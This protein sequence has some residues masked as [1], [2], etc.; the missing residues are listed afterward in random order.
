VVTALT[1]LLIGERAWTAIAAS[2]LATV[3]GYFIGEL[4]LAALSIGVSV[5]TLGE[6][7]DRGRV[8]VATA[9]RASRPSRRARRSR[10]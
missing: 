1:L 4:Q 8:P 6:R 7:V 9:R 2:C 5:I 3:I 10:R